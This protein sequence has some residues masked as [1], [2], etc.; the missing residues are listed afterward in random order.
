MAAIQAAVKNT[1]NLT[2]V[3]LKSLYAMLH[4]VMV[5]IIGYTAVMIGNPQ[6][7]ILLSPKFE[8]IVVIPKVIAKQVG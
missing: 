4:K 6:A 3:K 7:R 5:T 1:G 2:Q 8:I